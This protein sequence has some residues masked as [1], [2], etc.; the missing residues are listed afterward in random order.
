MRFNAGDEVIVRETDWVGNIVKQRLDEDMYIVRFE[1]YFSGSDLQLMSEA[2][3][4]LKAA[5]KVEWWGP[6]R[7]AEIERLTPLLKQDI[8]DGRLSAATI[9]SMKKLGLITKV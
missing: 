3:A 5:K 6:G 2:E 9:E 7:T 8:E 1:R 4:E